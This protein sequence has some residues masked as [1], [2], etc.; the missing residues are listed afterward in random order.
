VHQKLTSRDHERYSA[1][2]AARLPYVFKL[3]VM[4]YLFPVL[5]ENAGQWNR[6][7]CPHCL[8]TRLQHL[9]AFLTTASILH[10]RM[11]LDYLSTAKNDRDL[12][13]MVANL[14]DG[15]E[16]TYETILEHIS[17]QYPDRI[18][19]VKLLLQ[20]LVVASPTLT[21]ADLAEILAMRPKQSY[22]DFD[23]V[24]TDPYDVLEVIAP[25][26]ILTRS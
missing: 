3:F 2:L 5:P 16:H 9:R 18:E 26:V 20:C 15:L 14:P 22:L 4:A 10:A 6:A 21:A 24:A 8:K 13:A 1:T 25:L 12:K 7:V 19:E 17:S 11:Q 23:M